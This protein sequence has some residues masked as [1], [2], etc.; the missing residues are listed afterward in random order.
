MAKKAY[1]NLQNQRFSWYLSHV[2]DSVKDV[3]FLDFVKSINWND[4]LSCNEELLEY[5]I[6]WSMSQVTDLDCNDFPKKSLEIFGSL[7]T[8]Q[9]MKNRYV[10]SRFLSYLNRPGVLSLQYAYEYYNSICTVEILKQ[11][12][13]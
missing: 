4:S 6:G 10:T 11:K 8:D 3:D 9:E 2:G 5:M 12:A 1:L 13:R 7:V